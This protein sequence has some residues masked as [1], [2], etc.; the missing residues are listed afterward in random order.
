MSTVEELIAA[1]SAEARAGLGQPWP[2]SYASV[3]TVLHPAS[4]EKLME[5]WA[6]GEGAAKIRWAEPCPFCR[7]LEHL[8]KYFPKNPEGLCHHLEER[9]TGHR[10]NVENSHV[11]HC[12]C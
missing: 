9:A 2:A 1:L 12:P 10:P 4:T 6:H 7:C 8:S 11:K 3:G 5:Y